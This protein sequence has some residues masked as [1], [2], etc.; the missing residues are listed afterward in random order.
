MTKEETR[1]YNK[2]YYLAN[3][4][5]IKAQVK[6]YKVRTGYKYQLSERQKEEANERARR[7]YQANKQL[8]ID[9][10]K[11]WKK[12]NKGPQS[13]FGDNSSQVDQTVLSYLR[14]EL[15]IVLSFMKPDLKIIF[16]KILTYL[17]VIQVQQ[18]L[19]LI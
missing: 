7:W 17:V 5:K 4:E 11:E 3:K 1:A 16:A 14:N 15:C 9:R 18:I 6:N 8:M 13:Q 19:M 2:A 10:A 12:N